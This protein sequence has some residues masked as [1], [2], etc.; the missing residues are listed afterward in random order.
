MSVDAVDANSE[1]T[2]FQGPV[3]TYQ[4]V[5]ENPLASDSR[6]VAADLYD[7]EDRT[8]GALQQQ[9][10]AIAKLPE[11]A[12]TLPAKK[13]TE[14][15]TPDRALTRMYIAL[16]AGLGVLTALAVVAFVLTPGKTADDSYD[17][18]AVTSTSTGL[19]G[20]L[21]TEWTTRLN[22][23]LTVEPSDSGQLDAFVT[24]IN[25]PS[26]PLEVNLQLKDVTGKVLCTAPIL[27]KYD[28]LKNVPNAA[29][30][31]S[32]PTGAK[33]KN[34]MLA[35]AAE[36]QAQIEQS[37]NNARMVS[38]ELAREHGKDIFQTVSGKD[39]QLASLAAEGTL[40]CTKKQYQSAASWAFTTNFPSILQPVGNGDFESDLASFGAPGKNARGSDSFGG[41]A[42]KQK[43]LRP[44]S[45][46]AVEQDDELVNYEAS[47]G[48]A[49]T[50]EGKTFLVEKR[51]MVAS[52]LRGVEFPIPIHYRCDQL[53]A[54]ALF[55]LHPG[56]QRAW[57]EN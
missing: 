37:L 51:D 40:P 7:D 54:C 38:Q 3:S 12:K 10:V 30:A 45:H 6:F 50:R 11:K 22:Y 57:L 43:A 34:A 56:I 5:A 27:L 52:S 33:A 29:P 21:T 44:S 20:R 42:A 48:L 4:V 15:T 14:S 53:G 32:S 31:G 13:T 39:G 23:K 17:M 28:P 16:G 35:E 9:A 49:E 46:F 18:G 1:T 19:K 26:Q 2:E 41:R 8:A 55:G 24:A 36:N 25:H 47:T